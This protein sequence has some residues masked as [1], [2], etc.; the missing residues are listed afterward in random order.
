MILRALLFIAAVLWSAPVW[1]AGTHVNSCSAVSGGTTTAACTINGV[2]AGNQIAVY[3][4]NAGG[5]ALSSLVSD[6][7]ETFSTP[8]GCADSGGMA[9]RYTLSAV[10]GNTLFTATFPSGQFGFI[11]VHEF[12]DGGTY[13]ACEGIN[14]QTTPGTGADA[15]TTGT[16]VTV[17]N[18]AYIF[19]AT[20]ENC[21]V[22][23]TISAGTNYTG[24]T[25]PND[26]GY[27]GRSESWDQTTGG[28]RS[29]TFTTSS[30]A[31]SFK[32]GMMAFKPTVVGSVSGCYLMENNTDF[33]LMENGTDKYAL[34][35]G[36]GGLCGDA[37]PPSAFPVNK[38]RKIERMLMEEM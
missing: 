23:S 28:T 17:S 36:D 2:T 38:R 24:R 34:E 12:T 31:A 3:V 11:I 33:Y 7:G 19:A 14:A 5:V 1:S 18:N 15:I 6:K 20:A 35:G 4:A 10:G 22:S 30:G 27:V 26:S 16:G 29:G 13:E 21:C 9:M 37:P 32:T 8:A 25:S